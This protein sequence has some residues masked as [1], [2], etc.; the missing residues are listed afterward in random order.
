MRWWTQTPRLDEGQPGIDRPLRLHEVLE[1][2][3]EHL[4][5]PPSDAYRTL[6]RTQ[7][8]ELADALDAIESSAVSEQDCERRRCEAIK[9]CDDILVKRLQAEL[10]TANRA[11]LCLSGG[12]IR[13]ATFCLGIIQGL[14][15]HG[16]LEP[17]HYLSTVSGGG[18]IGSWLSAWINRRG[19]RQVIAD[20][21]WPYHAAGPLDPEPPEMRHLRS[22]SNY[23]TPKLGWLSADT[24]AVVAAYIR[25][26]I[27]NWI[28][29]VPL[30][31]ALLALPRLWIR[32]VMWNP[33][34]A[35][36]WLPEQW[37]GLLTYA[38]P[39]V[40]VLGATLTL[41]AMTYIALNLPG[42]RRGQ[43][44]A[45]AF[46]WFLQKYDDQS[47]F[48]RWCLGPLCVAAWALVTFWVWHFRTGSP[49]S[50]WPDD[51]ICGML[52]EA[53]DCP[54]NPDLG[55][56]LA[57]GFN[58]HVASWLV[59]LGREGRYQRVPS[60]W[61]G[62]LFITPAIA[63]IGLL[64]GGLAWWATVIVK[65]GLLN[66][67]VRPEFYVVFGA[68]LLLGVLILAG[69]PLVGLLSKVTSDEDRE[70][71]ARSSGWIMIAAVTWIGLGV[72][73][74]YVPYWIGA[75][76]HLASE[77]LNDATWGAALTGLGTFVSGAVT[78]WKGYS[79]GTPADAQQGGP[80]VNRGLKVSATLFVLFLAV[81]LSMATTWMLK[82][83]LSPE[84]METRSLDP[85]SHFAT[86]RHTPVSTLVSFIITLSL[87]SV[88]AAFFIH[89]NK[90]S[91]HALYRNRLTLAYLAASRKPQERTPVRFTGFD[92]HDNLAM[93]AL[94]YEPNN[95]NRAQR[96]FH[97]LNMALNL[98]DTAN[99]AWQERKAA[100][101]SVTPLHAGSPALGYRPSAQYAQNRGDEPISLGTAMAI[102]GAAASP[103]AGYHSSPAI[104]FLMTLFNARL[105]WW[106]P[107][108]GRPGQAT[109]RYG[110]PRWALGPLLNEAF[111]DTDD[112]KRYVNVSDGGH[113]ENLGLYEMVLRR[114]RFILVIDASQ[115]EDCAFDDVGNTLRKI[116]IDLGVHITLRQVRIFPRKGRQAGEIPKYCAI[117]EIHYRELGEPENGRL[118][119]I[120]P[121]LCPGDLILAE[122]MDVYNYGQTN[123]R[124]PH[125]DTMTD[126]WFSES[127]FE[128]YR[129]LGS[130]VIERLWHVETRHAHA[131]PLSD[132]FQRAEDY[133]SPQ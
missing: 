73:V 94:C 46:P 98:V 64:G 25:N 37:H 89:I 121:T 112:R 21:Q 117:G 43:E 102:S 69:V 55:A 127:Q 92:E 107:N 12:G 6:K 11:A 84:V 67:I 91:L 28:L 113:F 108:P 63:V 29:L 87:T 61:M 3:A 79:H 101:F 41:V 95:L 74:I 100:P 13:S 71:W 76:M 75:L 34:I 125:D 54:S 93:N 80:A 26:L 105:G 1:Q 31:I 62:V 111:G 7:E 57:F 103:N 14:A 49:L 126:Q 9:R 96:P 52:G 77:T 18:Y 33:T 104:T 114:C 68:P 88:L 115:D 128:S 40:F 82:D 65:T 10:N 99:L 83:T 110:S 8:R 19:Q 44:Q 30:F 60:W 15:R 131:D 35:P 97:V 38:K 2:E 4:K 32:V 120:K 78:A 124:F 53:V 27:L 122:P 58:L 130:H 90:F 24:W 81:F 123:P 116:R 129:Q 106:L 133:L 59:A 42:F 17:F 70:W 36:D 56:F 20:L 118:I 47:G 109:Y 39:A 45:K 48:L 66:P 51:T 23:W 72:L 119:Y 16:W 132:L 85:L 5:H 22:Y 50:L 86:L